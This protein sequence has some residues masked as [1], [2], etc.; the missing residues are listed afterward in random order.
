MNLVKLHDKTFKPFIEKNRIAKYVDKNDDN[1]EP[2]I[3][4]KREQGVQYSINS[5]NGF[6]WMNTNKNAE[7]KSKNRRIEVVLIPR[8]DEL[9]EIINN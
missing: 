5:W 9:F 6:F 7:G 4:I 2:K 8:L 1:L 3:F